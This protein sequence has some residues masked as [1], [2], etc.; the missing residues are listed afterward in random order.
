MQGKISRKVVIK[1]CFEG[2]LLGGDVFL[3]GQS[4]SEDE[5]FIL[6]I[7]CQEK[8]GGDERNDLFLKQIKEK[9]TLERQSDLVI[10]YIDLL[11]EAY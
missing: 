2:E 1:A 4:F 3:L 11:L 9:F 10:K 5:K 8:A 7:V 6:K